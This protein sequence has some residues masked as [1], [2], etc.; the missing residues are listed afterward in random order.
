MRVLGGKVRNNSM[1]ADNEPNF[2]TGEKI[3][4]YLNK[5]N[6]EVTKNFSHEHFVVTG[7]MQG[8]FKLTDNG[9]AIGW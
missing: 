7:Y 8:K 5:D 2:E 9:K 1:V 6:Y 3:L 4:L